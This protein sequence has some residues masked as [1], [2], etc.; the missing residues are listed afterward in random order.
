MTTRHTF[1]ILM[2]GLLIQTCGY[3]QNSTDA[4]R[5]SS[6]DILG[7]AR[8]VA[9]GGAYSSI[10][11][12]LSTLNY[13][14]AGLGVY[15]SG[16]VI[17]SPG[18]L[19]SSNDA[20]YNGK[21]GTDAKANLNFGMLGMVST[22]KVRNG[23]KAKTSGWKAINYGFSVTRKKN[24]HNTFF[25]TGDSYSSSIVE[26]WRKN[27]IGSLP[28]DLN[29]FSEGL[30]WDT[31]LLDTVPGNPRDYIGSVPEY[32][33]GQS[34]WEETKGYINELSFAV[35]ANY[36]DK[37][38]LG[39]SL[40]N[41]H[42]SFRRTIEYGEYAL[43]TPANSEFDELLYTEKLITEGV[44]IN[45]KL[46]FIFIV[47]PAVRFS[48]AIH[49]PTYYQEIVDEYYTDL[50]NVM[51]DGNSYS[52]GSPVGNMV[53]NLST[54]ARAMAGIGIFFQKNG[55]LSF[56]YEF[57]DYGRSKLTSKSYA[58]TNENHDI[59]ADFQVTHN[60]RIGAE[61]KLDFITLR[62]GYNIFGSPMNS[63]VNDIISSAYSW[64]LG[65]RVGNAFFD[66]AY[67]K[68]NTESLFYMYNPDYVNPASLANTTTNYIISVGY[69]F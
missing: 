44:G 60:F 69:K 19:Y 68:R 47:S 49:T 12:D 53:Y 64:G 18:L 7:S 57:A 55:F 38:I 10:G 39:F 62:G 11:G 50:E 36:N 67:S 22:H 8:F 30:A 43:E 24:F 41:P 37:L 25:I 20:I 46:G 61:Y 26:L 40:G 16:E 6:Y 42:L 31:Y 51:G 34:Y 56:D 3:T 13:N 59:R 1:L 66:F 17:F 29:P 28:K 33:V 63:E 15:Q 32:G 23:S 14:P 5:F 58:F 9:L 4:Y 54:P 45:A 2:F 35:S 48:G 65:Y 21:T 52:S 27:A